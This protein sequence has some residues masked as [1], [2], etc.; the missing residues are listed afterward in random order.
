MREYINFLAREVNISRGSSVT[1]CMEWWI[2]AKCLQGEL[3]GS[4]IFLQT[5]MCVICIKQIG[6]ISKGWRKVS[7]KIMSSLRKRNV[8][9]ITFMRTFTNILNV[10]LVRGSQYLGKKNRWIK[11][12]V[13]F[14]SNKSAY[15]FDFTRR[16]WELKYIK[17][18]YC[19][20]C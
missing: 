11:F 6:P 19:Q 4:W 16:I 3:L 9:L 17:Q 14:S 7:L 2:W 13:L 12:K 5:K 8:V 18:K 10:C 15:L 20:L 1:Y